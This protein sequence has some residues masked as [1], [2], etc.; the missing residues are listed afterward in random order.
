MRTCSAR[1]GKDSRNK[2][3]TRRKDESIVKVDVPWLV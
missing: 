1:Q 2:W 3:R